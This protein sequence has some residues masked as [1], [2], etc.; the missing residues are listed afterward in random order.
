MSS[1]S[2]AAAPTAPATHPTADPSSVTSVFSDEYTGIS[3]ANFNPD[4]GQ[5]TVQSTEVIGTALN[6]T[7]DNNVLKYAGLNYQG[8]TFDVQDIS[9]RSMLHFDYWTADATSLKI[10]LINSALAT[11]A[12]AVETAYTVTI[13]T[14]SWQSEDLTL[15][16]AFSGVDLTKVDQIKIEGNGTVYMDNIYFY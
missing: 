3:G 4:W 6:G 1:G 2:A 9:G 15:S 13:T 14:D 16:T 12:T 7:D 8:I 10:F 5:A 11:G